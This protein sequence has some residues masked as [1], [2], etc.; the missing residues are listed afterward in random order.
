MEGGGGRYST[1]EGQPHIES[2][3]C[4]DGMGGG[5]VGYWSGREAKGPKFHLMLEGKER[6]RNT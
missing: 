1:N 6:E 3:S 2:Y 4:A 5:G